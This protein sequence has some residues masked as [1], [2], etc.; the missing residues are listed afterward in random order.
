MLFFD[1]KL[2]FNFSNLS[3]TE[4]EQGSYKICDSKRHRC[5]ARDIHIEKRNFLLSWLKTTI[6]KRYYEIK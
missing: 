3:A 2:S 5:K 4:F 6:F 1:F